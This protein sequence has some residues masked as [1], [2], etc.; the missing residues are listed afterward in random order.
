MKK[1]G[2]RTYRAVRLQYDDLLWYSLILAFGTELLNAILHFSQRTQ[3][4][5]YSAAGFLLALYICLHYGE[6]FKRK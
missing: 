6:I 2:N 1:R 4:A 3:V 5:L